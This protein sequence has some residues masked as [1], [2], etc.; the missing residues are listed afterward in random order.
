MSLFLKLDSSHV[1]P[2][3]MKSN[4]D[5]IMGSAVI[6]NSNICLVVALIQVISTPVY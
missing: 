4:M 1:H 2:R 5:L 3:K 6:L